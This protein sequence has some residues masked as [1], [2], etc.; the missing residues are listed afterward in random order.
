MR[1]DRAE[2]DWTERATTEPE[3]LVGEGTRGTDRAL[4]AL[5]SGVAGAGRSVRG[6]FQDLMPGVTALGSPLNH[7]LWQESVPSRRY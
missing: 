5:R 1:R 6:P 7:L 2:P 4:P 3:G